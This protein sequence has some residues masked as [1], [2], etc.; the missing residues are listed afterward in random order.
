LFFLFIRS[1]RIT[2]LADWQAGITARPLVILRFRLTRS[3]VQVA[4]ATTGRNVR[5]VPAANPPE[6]VCHARCFEPPDGNAGSSAFSLSSAAVC[7]A[8]LP[9]V[10][11]QTTFNRKKKTT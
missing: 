8:F 6:R 5:D 1:R 11:E 3:A 10:K 2:G 4:P 9:V 7:S